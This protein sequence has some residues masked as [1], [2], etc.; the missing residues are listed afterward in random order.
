MEIALWIVSGLLALANLFVGSMKVVRP[1]EALVTRMAWAGD[2]SPLQLKAIGA[3]EIAGALGLI[4]PR[5]TGI[6]PWLSVAAA[7]GLAIL[8]LVA[9]TVHV[10]RKETFVPNLVLAALALFVGIGLLVAG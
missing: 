8:Q 6:L 5:L 10:R 2:F 3:L 4:L 7:F 9:L 1:K